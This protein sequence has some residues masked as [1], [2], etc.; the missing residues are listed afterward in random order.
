MGI[1]PGMMPIFKTGVLERS[2]AQPTERYGKL[3]G[4]RPV[5][6]H[7]RGFDTT[8]GYVCEN[9]QSRSPMTLH[10]HKHLDSCFGLYW[11]G[12]CHLRF[13]NFPNFRTA[14]GGSATLQ[15]ISKHLL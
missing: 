13:S 1:A 7:F 4:F 14:G 3:K 8:Y 15:P 12:V 11:L 5:L 6:P 2:G 10:L 9:E